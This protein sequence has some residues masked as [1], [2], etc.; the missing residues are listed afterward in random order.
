MR[1]ALPQP[2]NPLV[3][4]IEENS[5]GVVVADDGSDQRQGWTFRLGF[6]GRRYIDLIHG[7]G[8]H[9]ALR[10]TPGG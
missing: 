6:L 8:N 9:R 10:R 3:R 1:F 5:D 7:R 2:N 4:P